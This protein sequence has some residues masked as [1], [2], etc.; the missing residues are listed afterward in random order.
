MRLS[1]PSG[2]GGLYFWEAWCRVGPACEFIF[3]SFHFGA[4]LLGRWP[5]WGGDNQVVVSLQ[6]LEGKL[7]LGAG[8]ARPRMSQP[9]FLEEAK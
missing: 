9:K 6:G 5:L 1:R 8:P 3:N 2:A 4:L 7:G